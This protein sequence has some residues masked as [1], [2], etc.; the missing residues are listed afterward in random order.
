MG[1]IKT[2]QN[3]AARKTAFC[4]VFA[5]LTLVLLY[6]GGMTVLDLSVILI[7]SLVSV[8]VIIE[9][10]DKWG[11][12]YAAATSV[13]ALLLLPSKLYAVEY[14]L[15]SAVYPIIKPRIEKIPS[16]AVAFILKIASLDLML[17]GCVLLGQFVL[18]V[19]DEFFTL[20]VLTV[21]LGTVFFVLYDIVLTRCIIFY[22]AK[23]RK[24]VGL[25]KFL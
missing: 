11:F 5:A 21:V 1:K 7:C 17:I 12:I 8:V 19:G 18:H 24:T 6:F 9:T 16:K 2:G 3:T 20:G 13:L 23:L 22:L 10:G 25:Y 15:F 14:I 4:G